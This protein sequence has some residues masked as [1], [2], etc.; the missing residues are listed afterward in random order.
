MRNIRANLAGHGDRDARG[1]TRTKSR[2]IFATMPKLVHTTPGE[3]L[4]ELRKT[5]GLSQQDLGDRAGLDRRSISAVELGVNKASTHA[6]RRSLRR[7]L[8]LTGEE[9]DDLLDGRLEVDAA[10]ELFAARTGPDKT[11]VSVRRPGGKADHIE[12][13]DLDDQA[14][15]EDVLVT[16]ELGGYSTGS[17]GSKTRVRA[18]LK[19]S[20]SPS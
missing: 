7:G 15:S 3:I 10:A 17:P 13:E 14:T 1:L 16:R 5:L 2:S 19:A 9:F 18:A 4:A 20:R 12:L 8:A 6:L 11:K